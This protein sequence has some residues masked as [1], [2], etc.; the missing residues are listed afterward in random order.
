MLYA[1]NASVV[2][3]VS[4]TAAREWTEQNQSEDC[5]SLPRFLPHTPVAPCC[6][7]GMGSYGMGA[8]LAK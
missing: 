4:D 1:A 6:G 5:Q 8:F 3:L 7:L 2:A